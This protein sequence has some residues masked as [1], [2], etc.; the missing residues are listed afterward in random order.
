MTLTTEVTP[1]N[2]ELTNVALGKSVD[3]SSEQSHNP[4]SNLVDDDPD[5]RWSAQYYS[6][7]AEVDLGG[8]HT[9]SSTEVICYGDRAYQYVI[10]VSEDGISYTQVVDRSNNSKAGSNGS[11]IRD[12]FNDIEARYVR[13]S[14]TGAN[15]YSGDWI[16]I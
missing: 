5:S 9:I 6:Q 15:S 12:G 16:S 2:P 13:V 4:A 11:P 8:L 1:S 14:V 7:W 10:E 3:S